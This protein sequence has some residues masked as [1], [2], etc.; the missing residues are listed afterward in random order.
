MSRL[1]T[2]VV[3]ARPNFPKLAPVFHAL[4]PLGVTQ[5]VIHTGQHYDQFLSDA[6]F[7]LLDLPE[8]D[9]NLEVGSASHAVQTARIL[10][11]TERVLVAEPPDWL[12]VYGDVNS[13]AAAALV[14]AKLGVN[15]LRA[16]VGGDF[17]FAAQGD[18]LGISIQSGNDIIFPAGG[19]NGGSCGLCLLKPLPPG[20][21][22][23]QYRLVR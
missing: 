1:V 8:P 7:R 16:V 10:E 23:S 22:I 15:G 19:S 14:A 17:Q 13:T 9:V 21:F 5:R 12:V 4:A 18:F 6:F 11:G 20:V 3:G 2:H